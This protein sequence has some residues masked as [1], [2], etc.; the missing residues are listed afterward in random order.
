MRAFAESVLE[1]QCWWKSEDSLNNIWQYGIC[2]VVKP[3][4]KDTQDRKGRNSTEE[5]RGPST[6][7]EWTSKGV[8]KVVCF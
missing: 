7:E 6:L 1:T 3:K 2:F 5:T 8:E 4:R